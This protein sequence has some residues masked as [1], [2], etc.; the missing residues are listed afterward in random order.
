MMALAGLGFHPSDQLFGMGVEGGHC[1]SVHL[2]LAL[3]ESLFL[4][5][6][7]THTGPSLQMACFQASSTVDKACCFNGKAIL[8]IPW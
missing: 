7:L 8:A 1:S 3:V 2:C 6:T 4:P 5:V